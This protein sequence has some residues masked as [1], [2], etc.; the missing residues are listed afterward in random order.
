M[1]K[2]WMLA[3]VGRFEGHTHEGGEG[4]YFAD[5]NIYKNYQGLVS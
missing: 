5:S 4:L 2:L 3:G 1:F